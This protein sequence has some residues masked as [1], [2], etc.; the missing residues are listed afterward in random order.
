[1]CGGGS[2]PIEGAVI[3]PNAFQIGGDF[4]EKAIQRSVQL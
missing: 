4:H 3:Y 2:I 1:M